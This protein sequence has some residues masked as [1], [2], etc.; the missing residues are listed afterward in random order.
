MF[1]YSNHHGG[2]FRL[3][4]FMI[5][6]WLRSF[7]T[8]QESGVHA[9]NLQIK[10]ETELQDYAHTRS[11]LGPLSPGDW[12]WQM[13]NTIIELRQVGKQSLQ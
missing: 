12:R 7:D 3:N 4:V 5:T 1:R 9:S 8:A 11:W 10:A 2:E 13:Q 6:N